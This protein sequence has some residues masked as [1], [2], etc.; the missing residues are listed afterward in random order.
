ML[1]IHARKLNYFVFCIFS[2]IIKIKIMIIG[3]NIKNLLFYISI[4][5][6]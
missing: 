1:E 4:F 6:L 5:I 3:L 2:N